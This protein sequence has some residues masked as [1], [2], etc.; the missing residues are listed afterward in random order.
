MPNWC[1]D[2]LAVSGPKTEIKKFRKQGEANTKK[3]I[4]NDFFAQFV[5][6][7][8]DIFRGD[9]GQKEEALYGDKTWVTWCPANWGTKWDANNCV[10]I[11]EKPNRVVYQF[12]TAWGPPIQWLEKVAAIYPKL[13]FELNY[14]EPGMVFS[15]TAIGK[16]GIVV[17]DYREG[18]SPSNDEMQDEENLEE[19]RNLEKSK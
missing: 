16:D 4:I 11:T 6:Y 1:E 2:D 17:D 10:V 14:D 9:V 18:I 12:D 8:K 15:G 13:H 19:A 5:P 7:P 3:K